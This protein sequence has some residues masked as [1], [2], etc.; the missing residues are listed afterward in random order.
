MCGVGGLGEPLVRPPSGQARAPV[1]KWAG[2][3]KSLVGSPRAGGTRECQNGPEV[4]PGW[5]AVSRSR[6]WGTGCL[7]NFSFLR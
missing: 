6:G 7:N 2:D 5:Q 4:R 1:V 3:T